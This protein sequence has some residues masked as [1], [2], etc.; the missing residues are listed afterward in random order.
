VLAYGVAICSSTLA[1]V[2]SL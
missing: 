1:F 2:G